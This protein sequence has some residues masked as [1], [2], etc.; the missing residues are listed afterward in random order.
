MTGS[1]DNIDQ[2]IREALGQ[3]DAELLDQF[4]EQSI[5][6]RAIETFVGRRRLLMAL[7]LVVGLVLAVTGVIAWLRF[8]EATDPREMKVWGGWAL[9]CLAGMGG[10]KVWSWLELTR[11]ALVREVKRLE[12]QVAK[13]SSRGS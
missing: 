10:V 3:S 11:T 1:T 4:G 5:F 7:T 13:L 9:L 12:L 2:L 6:E 8:L